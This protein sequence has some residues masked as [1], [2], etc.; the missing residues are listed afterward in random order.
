MPRDLEQRHQWEDLYGWEEL[1]HWDNKMFP[2]PYSEAGC[3][4]C[5]STEPTVKGADVLSLGLTLIEKGAC[6][7]CHQ[8]E[9]YADWER[10][11]PNLA[12]LR[13][14]LTRDFAFKWVRN[15][16][17]LRH[18]AW[19]PSFFNPRPVDGRHCRWTVLRRRIQ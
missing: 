16:R 5:H 17:S 6:F 3:F 8:L 4:K 10:R 13:S 9:R 2:A 1:H 19:M 15:P 11:G 7:G 18:N 12:L 14:K